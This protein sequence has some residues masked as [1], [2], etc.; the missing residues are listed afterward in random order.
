VDAK[1]P[2]LAFVEV[3][4][5]PTVRSRAMTTAR[6]LAMAKRRRRYMRAGT[7]YSC[8]DVRL[9]KQQMGQEMYRAVQRT[10]HAS[11]IRKRP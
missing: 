4:L 7:S 8:Y 6:E 3:T 5:A 1:P 10:V 9:V 11:T 2:A